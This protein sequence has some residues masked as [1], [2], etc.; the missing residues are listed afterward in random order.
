MP[1]TLSEKLATWKATSYD[2]PDGRVLQRLEPPTTLSYRLI[3]HRPIGYKES[4]ISA[5]FN[6]LYPLRI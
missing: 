3:N 1:N 4:L 6:L 2:W 5:P